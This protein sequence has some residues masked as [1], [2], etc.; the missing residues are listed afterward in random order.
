M[1]PRV[2]P[3]GP[4]RQ[5]GPAARTDA[6]QLTDVHAPRHVRVRRQVPD[7]LAAT[8]RRYSGILAR[9]R[10]FLGHLRPPLRLDGDQRLPARRASRRPVADPRTRREQRFPARRPDRQLVR[11]RRA[12]GPD[13][14]LEGDAREPADLRKESSTARCEA[15]CEI[16]E[17]LPR[18][19]LVASAGPIGRLGTSPFPERERQVA[20]QAEAPSC[21]NR[22]EPVPV[23]IGT[24]KPT[25]LHAI[26]HAG[27][28]WYCDG[29]QF[30]AAAWPPPT[31]PDCTLSQRSISAAANLAL[32]V[33]GAEATCARRQMST[34]MRAALDRKN[35]SA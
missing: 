29:P 2:G 1:Q 26:A 15:C 20:V 10:R 27:T 19:L 4:V 9:Q 8:R 18:Q 13:T 21:S 11:E 35:G 14:G 25:F 5:L 33:G 17:S 23:G 16:E 30:A 31:T 6:E 22:I 24:T 34:Q 32:H 3:R 28:R 12:G 7:D